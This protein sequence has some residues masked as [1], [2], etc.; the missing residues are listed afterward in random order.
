LLV[1]Q[2]SHITNILNLPQLPHITIKGIF[3]IIFIY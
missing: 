1:K 2:L 3:D